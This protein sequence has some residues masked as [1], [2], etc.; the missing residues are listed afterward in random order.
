MT[1]QGIADK[2]RSVTRSV[3]DLLTPAAKRIREDQAREALARAERRLKD[4]R[5]LMSVDWGRRFVHDLLTK[6]GT[7]AD[8]FNANPLQ[9]ARLAGRRS[10][11]TDLEREI[12]QSDPDA[13]LRMLR[14][15]MDSPNA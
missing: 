1:R 2:A 13:F 7:H 10:L 8:T 6:A 12:A 9:M 11:G 4:V 15:S 3:V 14:E 5:L